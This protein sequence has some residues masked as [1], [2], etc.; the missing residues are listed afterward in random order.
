M[1][2][3]FVLENYGDYLD[4]EYLIETSRWAEESGFSSIWATDHVLPPRINNFPRFNTIT[5][6]ITTISFLAGVTDRIMVGISTLVLPLRNP[7]LV[8]K[9]L[10]SLDYL[11]QGRVMI[12]FGAGLSEG[13]FEFMNMS[14]SNRG[15]RF[16]E[17]L[18][19]VKSLWSGE[20]TFKGRHYSFEDASF[21][22][23]DPDYHTIPIWIAGN[24]ERA[25]RRAIKYAD[26]WHPV[27][28]EA[29]DIIKKLDAWDIHPP[30]NGFQISVR[31]TIKDV[32][33]LKPL[34][35][36]FENTPV[37]YLLLKLP[38]EKMILQQVSDDISPFV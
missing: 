15:K 28:I 35:E 37:S 14:F 31:R 1:Q 20:D 6:A 21:S 38:R 17:S 30:Q 7:I 19:L 33:S 12:S 34:L 27:N 23:N 16:D 32:S 10:S 4:R 18:E 2:F 22:P 29:V 11:T 5:E 13:E 9:Q 24:S 8:A 36:S 3:G 26:G 25:C